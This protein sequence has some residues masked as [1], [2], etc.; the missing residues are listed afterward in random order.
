[1]LEN[2]VFRGRKSEYRDG[3]AYLIKYYLS[4]YLKIILVT[5]AFNITND[6]INFNNITNNYDNLN[7]WQ[8]LMKQISFPPLPP[9]DLCLLRVP[10]PSSVHDPQ[11]CFQVPAYCSWHSILK[12]ECLYFVCIN[13]LT[14]E[15]SIT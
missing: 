6:N 4:Q 3:H 5:L 12:L 14:A 2:Y 15:T 11:T 8:R 9:M 1:M 10:A 7:C 13:S